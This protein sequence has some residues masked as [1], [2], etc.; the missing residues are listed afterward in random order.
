MRTEPR[1]EQLT[2]LVVLRCLY[3]DTV[4]VRLIQITHELDPDLNNTEM[5]LRSVVTEVYKGTTLVFNNKLV[6]VTRSPVRYEIAD[7]R[8]KILQTPQGKRED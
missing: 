5:N 1:M 2:E 7:R 6:V 3:Y 8:S 4:K